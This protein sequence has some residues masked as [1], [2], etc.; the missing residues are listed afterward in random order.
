M[1]RLVLASLAAAVFSTSIMA[2]EWIVLFDG[3]PTD[4]LRGYKQTG[5]PK[6]NWVIDGDALKTVPG[7][8]VDLVTV[9]KFQNYELELEWKVQP[10]GNSGVIYNVVEGP[11]ATYM[12]GP[13]MQ[14]LDDD[15]HPDG[16]NPKTS[17]GSLY[18]M[19]APNGEK[20]LKPVGQWNSAKLLIKDNHVEHWLN[21]KKV[22][23]YKWG[24]DEMKEW[25]K[26]SK[27][28]DMTD[29]AKST[30]GGHIAFQHHGEEVWYRNIRIRKL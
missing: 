15:K 5:F 22:V 1:K 30:N 13:E 2:G 6:E 27:F 9:E 21:G 12:T 3:K 19:V 7:K 17:S 14:V 26:N 18:A 11:G 4:K 28:K 29:F 20:S 16:K 8:A 24:S 10:A 25:I 23:E